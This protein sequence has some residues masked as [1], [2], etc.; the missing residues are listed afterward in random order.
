VDVLKRSLVARISEPDLHERF[1]QMMFDDI[2]PR[3]NV[4]LPV[5]A[6]LDT[7]PLETLVF[8]RPAGRLH[9]IRANGDSIVVS[10][11]GCEL[12]L[13]AGYRTLIERIFETDSFAMADLQTWQPGVNVAEASELL[14]E[15]LRSGLLTARSARRVS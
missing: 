13:E 1:W 14:R 8:D 2:R 7:V 11:G 6:R 15:L 12:A 9:L 10:A 3:P 5:Q 4:H